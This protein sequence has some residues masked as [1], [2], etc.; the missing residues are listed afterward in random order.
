MDYTVSF[1]KLCDIS[2]IKCTIYGIL[3]KISKPNT[4]KQAQFLR[5][6][7]T[8]LRQLCNVALEHNLPAANQFHE[9]A[10]PNSDHN[11][12]FKRQRKAQVINDD[13]RDDER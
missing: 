6:V 9:K 11:A 3:Y 5:S 2:S 10:L 4:T 7:Y 8:H 12:H 13:A 1:E